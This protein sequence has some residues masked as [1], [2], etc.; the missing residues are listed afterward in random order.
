MDAIQ[1]KA[2][3]WDV[4]Y[5]LYN[6]GQKIK[7][8]DRWGISLKG[9]SWPEV[10]YAKCENANNCISLRSGKLYTCVFPAHAKFLKEKYGLNLHLSERNGVDI[11][12]VNS[13]EELMDKLDRPIPFCR[14]CNIEGKASNIPWE[15][16]SCSQYEWIDFT[17][18]RQDMEYLKGKDIIVY[19]AGCFGKETVKRLH[20]EEIKID[21][22]VVTSMEDNPDSVEGVKVYGINQ[23]T[24][25]DKKKLFLV[26]VSGEK[27]N[28]IVQMLSKNGIQNIIFVN[29]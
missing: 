19:G 17:F 29:I 6:E 14:Y 25:A 24:D 21:K 7:T 4:E 18:S 5:R 26:A 22:I 13:P 12:K 11:Y 16:T 28:A 27:R 3:K 9:D 20:K 23:V 1:Q 2:G 10:N 8:L 15:R